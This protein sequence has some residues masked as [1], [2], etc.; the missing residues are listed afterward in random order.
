MPSCIIVTY[1]YTCTSFVSASMIVGSSMQKPFWHW[2]TSNA[3]NDKILLKI[4]IN[5][6]TITHDCW[7]DQY[8]PG[9]QRWEEIVLSWYFWQLR[10]F[11]AQ[12][13]FDRF[14][15]FILHWSKDHACS[16]TLLQLAVNGTL[17]GMQGVIQNIWNGVIF[18]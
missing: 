1:A 10:K 11:Y 3:V 17:H 8:A 13:I 6:K 4:I 7:L 14:Y 5:D 2:W 18:C 16:R 12:N 9:D 15:R